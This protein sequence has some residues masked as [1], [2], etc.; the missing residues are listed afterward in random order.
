MSCN[1]RRIRALLHDICAKAEDL[2][3]MCD[4]C[5]SDL[6]EVALKLWDA[7]TYLPEE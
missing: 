4:R 1:T 2:V 6:C 7:C 3:S 5:N